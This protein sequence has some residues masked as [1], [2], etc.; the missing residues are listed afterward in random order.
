METDDF[1]VITWAIVIIAPSRKNKDY[2]SPPRCEFS[3]HENIP[4][5]QDFGKKKHP[6]VQ[7]KNSR[8]LRTI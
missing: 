5:S 4:S 1:N 8:T 7:E 2:A 3:R 6:L